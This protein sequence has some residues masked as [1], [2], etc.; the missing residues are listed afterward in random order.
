M[1]TKFENFYR[2]KIK[3]VEQYSFSVNFSQTCQKKS[4]K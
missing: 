1:K 3:V 2:P 4:I